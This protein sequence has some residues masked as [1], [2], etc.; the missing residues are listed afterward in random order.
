MKIS[1]KNWN[2]KSGHIP[3]RWQQ[4]DYENQ[5][6]IPNHDK[7]GYSTNKLNYDIYKERLGL[8][9]LS[10][11]KQDQG[12]FIPNSMKLVFD[13]VP[14]MFDLKKV[15]Y[16]F[17]KYP[18]GN[19]LPWH[20]DNYPTYRKKN[21]VSNVESIVRIIV[22]LHDSTPGQQL[23]IN[24]KMYCGPAGSWFAWEGSTEH[25][26]ANLSKEPRY[27]LQITG[28]KNFDEN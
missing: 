14:E 21:N 19:I 8:H 7:R 1:Y 11:E 5:K 26:A 16:S 10:Y 9:I 12:I 25:M 6:W 27:V 23:W 15:I 2:H 17:M 24:D 4:D 20:V 22:L 28:T 13:Y 3:V 18:V